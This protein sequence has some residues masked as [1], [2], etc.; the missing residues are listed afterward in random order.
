MISYNLGTL[1]LPYS[2]L[3]TG[4]K[5]FLSLKV[6]AYCILAKRERKTYFTGVCEGGEE[7]RKI[8]KK[9][10]L[11]GVHEVALQYV[12]AHA[13]F[14][15]FSFARS[16]S[17]LMRKY[18]QHGN[19]LN[20]YPVF[21]TDVIEGYIGVYSKLNNVRPVVSLW[22]LRQ[23]IFW[24]HFHPPSFISFSILL[25]LFL[26]LCKCVFC[27]T[28]RFGKVCLYKVQL[29][30]RTE[31]K[32]STRRANETKKSNTSHSKDF[33]E[34]HNPIFLYTSKLLEYTI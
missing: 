2:R 4:C 21:Y 9:I 32:K 12:L 8:K 34:Y 14:F 25:F 13:V 22:D 15:S 17:T 23:R 16:E 27:L 11:W 3:N 30:N 18:L 26:C 7:T 24:I 20:I 5:F 6:L 33:S 28:T 10:V 31:K 1:P 29:K 19:H